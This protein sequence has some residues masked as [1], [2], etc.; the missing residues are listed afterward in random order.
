M[1]T[2]KLFILS[3]QMRGASF[4]LTLEKYTV[5]RA[6]DCNICIT[7]PTVSS[8]HCSL[9]KLDDGTF[10][11]ED[12]GS[13]NGTKVNDK[14]LQPGESTTLK[15]GDIIQVGSIEI[16]FDDLEGNRDDGRT[17]SVIDLDDTDTG[18]VNKTTMKNLGNKFG[19]KHTPVLRPNKSH[20][21]I[22]N[23]ILGLLALAVVV[24]I[25]MVLL[26]GGK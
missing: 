5:G 3:D 25:A 21:M 18:E 24:V 12:P 26:K 14:R 9:V 20:G 2:P 7:D 8:H 6:D 23:I 16:L 13:T 10:A 4:S 17:V 22:L 1:G 15:N 19:G 11:I